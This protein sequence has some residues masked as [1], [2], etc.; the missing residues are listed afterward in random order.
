MNATMRFLVWGTMPLGAFLGGVLGS[1]IGIRQTLLVVAI[2]GFVPVL[3]ILF[4]PLRKMRDLPKYVS[5]DETP[6]P[7]TESSY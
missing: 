6:S 7:V 2:C 4:S 3:P 1:T 5:P